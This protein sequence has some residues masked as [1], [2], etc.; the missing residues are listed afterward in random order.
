VWK[1]LF[2][3]AWPYAVI[4]AASVL[5]Q[6]LDQLT[7]SHF[8]GFELGGQYA[9]AVRLMAI[10]MMVANAVQ[11]AIFPDIQRVGRD[12]PEK[13]V[14]YVGASGKSLFRFGLPVILALLVLVRLIMIPLFPKFASAREILFWFAPGIWGYWLQNFFMAALYGRKAFRQVVF[15]HI[16]S[17]LVYVVALLSLVH[18]FG[19]V[20]VV[21]GYDIFC[22]ALAFFSLAALKRGGHV[23]ANFYL[24]APF[25]SA[26][27]GLFAALGS[28]IPW[29]SPRARTS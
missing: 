19:L 4:F 14:T 16:Y 5:W 2:R 11:I 20:G 28:R 9:L 23:P 3:D 27:R 7:A 15:V 24:W 21:W 6:R 10:P 22:L 12:A 25:T 1:S 26:E 8:L 17:L 29:L 18:W 13:I